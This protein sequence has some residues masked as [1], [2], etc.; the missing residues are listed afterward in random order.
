MKYYI[1]GEAELDEIGK[2]WQVPGV[3]GF[4]FKPVKHSQCLFSLLLLHWLV[5]RDIIIILFPLFPVDFRNR[6]LAFGS[7]ERTGRF[8]AYSL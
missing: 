7:E 4:L 1:I 5:G 2:E 6:K 3:L 8:P